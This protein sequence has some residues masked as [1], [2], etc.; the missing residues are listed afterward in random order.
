MRASERRNQL[1]KPAAIGATLTPDP[2]LAEAVKGDYGIR[3][4][5]KRGQFARGLRE[6]IL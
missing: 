6:A 1:R 3:S 5:A 2:S 4:Y